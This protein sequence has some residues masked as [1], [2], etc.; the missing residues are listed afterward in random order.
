MQEDEWIKFIEKESKPKTKVYA[1]M[2][3]CSDCE[4]GE[5]KWYPSWRHYCFFPT[6][7][8]ETVHS[9]RCLLS[10]SQ[11]ITKLNVEHKGGNGLPP[12]DKSVGIR[13][14]IL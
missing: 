9:D 12:T 14:T 7:E 3:K 10:I 5:I 2:S 13:P 8:L 6:L 1:V 11:F 4:L